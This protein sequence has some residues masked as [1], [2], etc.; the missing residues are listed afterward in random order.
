MMAT[1]F[2]LLP[3]KLGYFFSN[4]MYIIIIL[5]GYLLL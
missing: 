5:A 4:A 1:S 2:V 3:E